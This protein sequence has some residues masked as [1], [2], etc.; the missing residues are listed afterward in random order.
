MKNII[1]HA[2]LVASS[3]LVLAGCGGGSNSPSLPRALG[4]SSAAIPSV[5]FLGYTPAAI[6]TAYH[7]PPSTSTTLVAV[8][9]AYDYKS[10]A[11]DLAAYR[12][13]YSPTLCSTVCVRKVG[14]T[15]GAV[16]H[17]HRADWGLDSA[18]MLDAVTATCSTCRLLLVETNS[19]KQSDLYQ[20]V[21]T[22]RKLHAKYIVAGWGF[23]E[24]EATDKAFA[25]KGAVVVAA[26]GD[27]G[28]SVRSGGPSQ[29]C[30][31]ANVVCVGGTTLSYLAGVYSETLWNNSPFSAGATGS[32]C[33]KI[34][35]KP[36][37][38]TD[39]GC[40][41]RSAADVSAVADPRTPLVV[42][43]RG[44]PKLG[45][46]GTQVSAALVAGMMANAGDTTAANAG[47]KIWSHPTS[48]TD[49][50]SGNNLVR[51]L[52]PCASN[53]AYICSARVG[54]DGPTGW[55]SPNGLGAL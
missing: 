4:A 19:A 32:A 26:A 7:L 15:G 55:G 46:G 37:W 44:K 51:H 27:N 12:A 54:Y 29:P 41:M 45:I 39:K 11:S 52:G 33:S 21:E 43:Y 18:L 50:T 10:A 40:K 35:P 16:P 3:I 1:A 48:F 14:Q 13:T 30:T 42:I 47:A 36:S 28:G 8:V 17:S 2:A 23:P 25:N 22:A 6:A 31:F 9:V 49:I 34:V 24:S 38:Q 53:V 20:G 5:T